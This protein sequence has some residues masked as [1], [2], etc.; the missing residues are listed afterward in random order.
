MGLQYIINRFTSFQPI[1]DLTG[2]SE[3][4][5]E[6]NNWDKQYNYLEFTNAN[7][8]IAIVINEVNDVMMRLSQ[9]YFD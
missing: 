5:K 4:A 9:N 6:L 2:T 3:F 7:T 1:F 8:M